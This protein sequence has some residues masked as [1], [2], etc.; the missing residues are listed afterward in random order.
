MVRN[1]PHEK[2]EGARIWLKKL[3]SEAAKEIYELVDADRT[4]LGRFLPWVV[5]IHSVADE[6]E[7]LRI[8]DE[9]WNCYE[10]FDYGIFLKSDG[11]YLGSAGA[12][13]LSWENERCE[14]GYWVAGAFEGKGLIAEAV[15]LLEKEIFRLGF[16]RI[17]IRCDPNNPR[18]AAVPRRCGYDLEGVLRDQ[19]VE[20]GKRRSTM[21]WAKLF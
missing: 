20:N 6:E 18:S 16:H 10:F 2:L 15:G 4:R 11:R 7:Y 19:V 21:V 14:I 1:H 13:T 8:S 3:P 5:G 17:E 9:Q 12:H